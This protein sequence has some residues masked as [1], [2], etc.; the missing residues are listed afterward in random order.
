[1][2]RPSHAYT[3]FCGTFIDL[4]RNPHE[5]ATPTS[6]P[7]HKL[8]VNRGAVWVSMRDGRIKGID[9]RVKDEE[10]LTQLV[11]RMGWT[12]VGEEGRE[13]EEMEREGGK[14]EY[15]KIVRAREE[16][17]EFFFPGFVDAHI[18]APQYP[19]SGVFGNSTL[20]EWLEKYTFP[21]EASFEDKHDPE[22]VAPEVAHI[23][24]NRVVSRTLSHGTTCASYFATTHVPA[25]NLLADICHT[26]GQ[27][28][29][30]GRVCM[31]DPTT[32]PKDYRDESTEQALTRTKATISHIHKLDPSGTLVNPIITP[33]FAASC[34]EAALAEYGKLAA[35]SNPPMRIQ[36]HIAENQAEV[37]FVLE[38]FK[39]YK[40]YAEIYER[41]NLLTPLTILA[42]AVHLTPEEINMVS[43]HCSSVA[44]CPASNS[45]L[46]SGI[47]PVRKQLDAGVSVG[48]GTDV[49]GGYSSSILET[50][51]QACL[52]SRLIGFQCKEEE[53]EKGKD[54]EPG[55]P[56][57][58]REK[59]S[60]EEALYLATRGGAR[61]V[62]MEKDIGGFEEGMY[63]DAQMIT[64]GKVLGEEAEVE[65]PLERGNVD[66][67]GWESWDEAIAKWL[68][69][70][71]DRNVRMVWV[72]G[73][74]VHREK[75]I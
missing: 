3:L 46:G 25:T 57:V 40:S 62:G 49:A 8:A 28:A 35:S 24:Y 26:R 38:H 52:V 41:A 12:E 68:W 60:V 67:F 48:L 44:H 59:L 75:G 69:T 4:P 13:G 74:L 30:I 66:L 70:G 51:R 33:R 47:C 6:P 32:C 23:A 29:F 65:K 18:H 15:V 34:K 10:A 56:E 22:H 20:L 61:A 72:A 17:N 43:K 50:A 37:K 16:R 7:K 53:G 64:L 21:R 45:A 31:D 27:R 1:M 71:D 73:R 36:T 39:G 63:W 11:G 58:D 19:N 9:L 54:G 42:H 14:R 2:H 5:P 55:K